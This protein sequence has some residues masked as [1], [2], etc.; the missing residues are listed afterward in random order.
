MERRGI[1]RG[2]EAP[3]SVCW[4]KVRVRSGQGGEE[5]VAGARQ[6][7]IFHVILITW[8]FFLISQVEE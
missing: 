3:R 4:S 1:L 7:S 5:N 2:R 8:I 6:K